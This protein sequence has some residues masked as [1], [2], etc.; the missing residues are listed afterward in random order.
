MD[1]TRHFLPVHIA[2]QPGDSAIKLTNIVK[3]A[4]V[5]TLSRNDKRQRVLANAG[6][7][8]AEGARTLNHRIDSPVL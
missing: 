4:Q 6:V 1:E 5:L 7:S 2:A 3:N 8:E